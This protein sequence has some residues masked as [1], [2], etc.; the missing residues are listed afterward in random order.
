MNLCIRYI[1]FTIHHAYIIGGHWTILVKS[2]FITKG[3]EEI[4]RS[5]DMTPAYYNTLKIQ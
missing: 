2:L 5:P 4:P 1:C 3:K